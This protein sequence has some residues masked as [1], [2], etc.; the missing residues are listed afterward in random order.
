MKVILDSNILIADFRLNSP[1][2]KILLESSKQQNISLYVPEI[3][4]DEVINK[5]E[6]RLNDG[7]LKSEREISVIKKMT[8]ATF[9]DIFDDHFIAN[10]VEKYKKELDQIFVNNNVKIL[11]YPNTPHKKIVHK[12]IKKIKPF[13]ANEKGYRDALIWENVMSLIPELGTNAA[14]PEVIFI[15][16]NIKDFYENDSDLHHDLITDIENNDLDSEAL[17]IIKDLKEFSKEITE[18]FFLQENSFK[19]RIESGEIQDFD[20]E[21]LILNSLRE[22]LNGDISEIESIP[23]SSLDATVRYIEKVDNL[24][25][26]NVRRLNAHEYIID[27]KCNVEMTIDFYVDKYDYYSEEYVSYDVEELDYNDYVIWASELINPELSISL[28]LDTDFNI[29]SIQID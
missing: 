18:L 10:N 22:E 15:T 3:V 19:E 12:A 4:Y 16:S 1:D 28:I 27:L 14:N 29:V 26:I 2:S 25:I 11:P 13:N 20:L 8:D 17:K 21:D 23:Y 9:P 24:K 7:K 5:F 6:E